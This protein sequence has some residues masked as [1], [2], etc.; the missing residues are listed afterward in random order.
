MEW[1]NI[2]G[3]HTFKYPSFAFDKTL[4]GPTYRRNM[5]KVLALQ[6]PINPFARNLAPSFL[7]NILSRYSSVRDS[8]LKTCGLLPGCK[9]CYFLGSW[10]LFLPVVRIRFW[11]FEWT[12]FCA[13]RGFKE[14]D[15]FVAFFRIH[16]VLC[17]SLI[18]GIGWTFFGTRAAK[19]AIFWDLI[20]HRLCYPR[21]KCFLRKAQAA[22][23]NLLTLLA[24]KKISNFLFRLGMSKSLGSASFPS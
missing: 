15:T 24:S 14:P 6:N 10:T 16:M 12:G 18:Y 11:Q 13:S 23:F 19:Y 21:A 9:L 7:E 20:T 5:K 8:R 17:L 4:H 1:M 22:A 3:L 2:N